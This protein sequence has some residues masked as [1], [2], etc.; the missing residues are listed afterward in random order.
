MRKKWLRKALSLALAVSML[1]ANEMP[2]L[3]ESEGGQLRQR[4]RRRRRKAP[5]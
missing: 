5:R 2:A 4:K 1:A 3:A